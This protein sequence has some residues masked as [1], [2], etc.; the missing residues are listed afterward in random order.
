MPS[1]RC[2][3]LCIERYCVAGAP[4][5]DWR[6]EARDGFK[7]V[8]PL[9]RD[10]AVLAKRWSSPGRPAMR[11][12]EH[13]DGRAVA[14]CDE[15]DRDPI[16]LTHADRVMRRPC[17]LRLRGTLCRA[18][19]L[20]ESR[21]P[22]GSLPGVVR[23]GEW[24]PEPS[25]AAPVLL[26]GAASAAELARVVLD[27]RG[28]ATRATIVLTMTRLLWS[29]RLDPILAGSPIVL[30]P[31]EDVLDELDESWTRTSAWDAFAAPA[32]PDHGAPLDGA[33]P[34]DLAEQVRR[35]RP[36]E[37]DSI[38]AMAELKP[39]AKRPSQ[40]VL[41]RLA[42]YEPDATFKGALSNLVKSGLLDNDRHHG[43]RGGYSITDRGKLAARICDQS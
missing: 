9:L 31:L 23:I 42:G 3:L 4:L 17:E 6:R 41:A 26:V 1:P 18:L 27:L 29:S 7:L 28:S 39:T 43:G 10:T 19:S 12:V 21:E 22:P 16:E 14:V 35:M 20:H 2:S 24:R 36:I 38:M 15:G 32:L 13:A 8:E 40:T 34:S 11:I 37:R 5:V 30:I 33:A 25:V